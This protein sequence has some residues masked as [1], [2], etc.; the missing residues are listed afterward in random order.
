MNNG[1]PAAVGLQQP[2]SDVGVAP[3]RILGPGRQMPKAIADPAAT[4]TGPAG[5]DIEDQAQ[6]IKAAG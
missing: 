5:F 3:G 1:V 6:R 4:E 2:F